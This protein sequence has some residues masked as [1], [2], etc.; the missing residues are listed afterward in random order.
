MRRNS[1][2]FDGA[3]RQVAAQ[4]HPLAFPVT[5]VLDSSLMTLDA[6]KSFNTPRSLLRP[7]SLALLLRR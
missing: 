1:R 4:A 7:G 3:L 5:A 2:P 6:S